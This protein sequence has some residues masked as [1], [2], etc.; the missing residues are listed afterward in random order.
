M[1]FSLMTKEDQEDLENFAEFDA[2]HKVVYLTPSTPPVYLD[3]T[4]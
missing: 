1:T 3:L 4:S 2:V